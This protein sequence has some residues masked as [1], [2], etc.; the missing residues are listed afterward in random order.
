[1]SDHHHDLQSISPL[2]YSRFRTDRNL[3]PPLGVFIVAG[4]GA[5][6]LINLICTFLGYAFVTSIC[7]KARAC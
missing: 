4:C 5:D 1:L 6:L 7:P 3:V 2:S